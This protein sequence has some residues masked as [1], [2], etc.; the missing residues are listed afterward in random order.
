MGEV[1]FNARHNICVCG[2]FR[3]RRVYTDAGRITLQRH[4]GASLIRKRIDRRRTSIIQRARD[5]GV[6]GVRGRRK[7]Y[8][9]ECRRLIF[10]ARLFINRVAGFPVSFIT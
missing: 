2:H 9:A 1:A 5:E 8:Y 3:G 7:R 6:G 4:G 10:S